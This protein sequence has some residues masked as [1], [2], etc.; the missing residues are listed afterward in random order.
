M[1]DSY[2]QIPV[3]SRLRL[4]LQA[5]A[6]PRAAFVPTVTSTRKMNLNF[7][8]SA[9]ATAATAATANATTAATATTAAPFRFTAAAPKVRTLLFSS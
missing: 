1:L 6:T 4:Y 8:A 5:G 9:A 7:G 2:K 3:P